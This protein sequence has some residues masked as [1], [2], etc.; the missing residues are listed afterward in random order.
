MKQLSRT[1]LSAL[2]SAVAT[3]GQFVQ[4]LFQFIARSF[5]I[6][7]LGSQYLGL[8]GLFLNVLGYLNF[9][10]LGIGSAITF[11][12]YKPLF[13]QD[14]G[15]VSAIL[16]LF[17]NLY[18]YIALTVLLLGLAVTPLVP[19]LIGGNISEIHVNIEVAFLLALS[20]TVLSYLTTYK[21]TLLL[22]DQKGYINT[23]NSVGFNVAGQIFQIIQLLIWKDFYGYLIIQAVMMFLSNVWISHRVD[24][25]YPQ[26]AIKKAGKVG[27]STVDYLKKNVVGM[28]SAKVGGILVTGTDNILLS[29][30]SGLTAVGLYSNYVMI[31][32]GL[33]LLINQLLSA[34]SSSIGNLQASSASK[35]HQE[36]VFYHYFMVTSILSLI[37]SIGFAGF[38][39]AFVN[40]W[41]SK[42]MVY[43]FLPLAVI[44]VNFLLQSLRQCL[45]NYTNAY[46][47][48]WYER[49]K[50]VFEASLN[51]AISWVLVKFTNLS[52]SG[53]LLGT[54][55]SNIFVNFFWESYIVLKYGLHTN[56]FRFLRL[57]AGM[58]FGGSVLIVAT[59]FAITNFQGIKLLNGI[60]I[61]LIAECLALLIYL[62]IERIL[63][64]KE[65]G[66]FNLSS[67]FHRIRN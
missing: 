21:R 24:K 38:S 9:A 10:E 18:R 47:L 58:I 33:T 48:Y 8:N 51:L 65:I 41:L 26:V 5:F 42:N 12:L 46:G 25:L 17:R 30:Y 53:V 14:M 55:C 23:I 63:F 57:Y 64:P 1:R 45:I 20:D 67:L 61:T 31:I 36:T 56:T 62:I 49:W 43:S 35:E 54:I 3:I 4:L 16:K 52:V 44:S 40:V 11:S 28:F 7:I 22:A 60:G 13:D 37:M 15:Q 29:I 34:V 19:H 59:C 6:H 27:K 66:S 50:T 32:N 39:S 2:N